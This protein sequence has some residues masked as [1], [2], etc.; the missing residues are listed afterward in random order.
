MP[1]SMVHVVNLGG[2]DSKD[3]RSSQEKLMKR[4]RI[5]RIIEKAERPLKNMDK[6]LVNSFLISSQK[7]FTTVLV[8]N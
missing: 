5:S 7:G 3:I 4:E 6:T 1:V 8:S 2:T